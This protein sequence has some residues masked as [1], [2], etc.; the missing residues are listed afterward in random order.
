METKQP[1]IDARHLIEKAA[2]ARS[3]CL[4]REDQIIYETGSHW[5][6]EARP[7]YFEVYQ[8]GA[9]HSV[10]CAQIGP[11]PEPGRAKARAITECDRRSTMA[12]PFMYGVAQS[13]THTENGGA[14]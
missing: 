9:T 3:S 8:T 6:L 2:R 5:V 11:Y 1:G 7:G 13:M 14:K 10:R 4:P 12:T